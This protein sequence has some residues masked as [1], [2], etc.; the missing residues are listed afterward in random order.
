MYLNH[1]EDWWRIKQNFNASDTEVD[2]NHIQ[3]TRQQF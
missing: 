3:T 2:G 1:E